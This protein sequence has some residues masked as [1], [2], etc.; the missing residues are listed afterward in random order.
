MIRPPPRSPLFPSTTLFR[1]SFDWPRRLLT[2]DPE[3]YGWTQWLFVR[4]FENGLAYR[5]ESPVNWCPKDQTVLANEQV[6]QGRCERCG[7]PVER[8]GPAQGG[9]QI[10]RHAQRLTDTRGPLVHR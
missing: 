9:F 7:T 10:T 4:L 6:I 8:R 3:Y 2:S 5:K 1:S